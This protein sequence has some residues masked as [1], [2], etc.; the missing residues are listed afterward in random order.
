MVGKR[1]LFNKQPGPLAVH[2]EQ[3]K[4]PDPFL[5]PHPQIN[6]QLIKDFNVNG[7][8]L[9][10]LEENVE[11]LY[12]LKRAREKKGNKMQKVL[13]WEDRLINM[14]TG[15]RGTSVTQKTP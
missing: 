6:F 12:D 10:R 4:K 13:A 8:M 1:W 9:K 15:K 3:E 7:K 2:L 11:Y 5:T 14:D